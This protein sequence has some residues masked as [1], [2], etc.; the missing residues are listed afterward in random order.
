MERQSSGN[1][2][3]SF[4]AKLKEAL[5]MNVS[6]EREKYRLAEA[7]TRDKKLRTELTQQI[8]ILDAQVTDK[9]Q[10]LAS[11]SA[12]FIRMKDA[13]EKAPRQRLGAREA[14]LGTKRIILKELD[15]LNKEATSTEMKLNRAK[16]RNNILREHINAF[17]REQV[18]FRK[19][20]EKM[21]EELREAKTNITKAENEVEDAYEQRRKAHEEM[22]EL[23]KQFE[24]DKR[25]RQEEWQRLT[26]QIEKA[27]ESA[28]PRT[29]SARSGNS[30]LS[31]N[32]QEA[33]RKKIMRSQ[34][35]MQS[36][37]DALEFAQQKQAVFSA[38]LQH[39]KQ[40]T[41]YGKIADVIALFNR[42][43][44]EKFRKAQAAQRLVAEI[45][46]LE[47]DVTLLQGEVSSHETE[48]ARLKAERA[49][50]I[51]SL[52]HQ[53]AEA[54]AQVL[55]TQETGR[56]ALTEVRSLY[57]VIEFTFKALGIDAAVAGVEPTGA[58]FAGSG[59]S[60]P[61]RSPSIGRT[62]MSPARAAS[63]SS[64]GE[65]GAS[66]AKSRRQKSLS[67][68]TSSAAAQNTLRSGVS[69][70]S[71]GAYIGAIENRSADILQQF[72]VLV[73]RGDLATEADFDA[74]LG[75]E[76]A[77]G[78][79]EGMELPPM[80]EGEVPA[81]EGGTAGF[82]VML[83]PA[84]KA[85][86]RRRSAAFAHGS[87]EMAKRILSPGGLGPSNPPG[88]VKAAIATSA[89]IA[90]ITMDSTHVTPD[91]QLEM[92]GAGPGEDPK[93]MP[94]ETLKG[95]AIRKLTQDKSIRALKTAASAAA[96]VLVQ[97][98]S[99]MSATMSATQ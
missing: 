79:E 34:E 74:N 50:L 36:D 6:L 95:I 81:E 63:F 13:D 42:F 32:E 22:K 11:Y 96:S 62:P 25:E 87:G 61:A 91:E 53:A 82:R 72:A 14:V 55:E 45:E 77:E 86:L 70:S 97:P 69:A 35:K 41:G 52:D 33:L 3:P 23:A 76:S 85:A 83:S 12:L 44:E 29:P 54:E 19:L 21:Q 59:G 47:K 16:E 78:A 75:P 9:R 99:N 2:S 5:A 65:E 26:V 98:S 1:Q 8:M 51:G 17:R 38:A 66:P 67:I 43:E 24:L 60:S 88:R 31:P 71:L 94:T 10:K 46:R 57:K 90:S 27:T 64:F 4:D 92:T 28:S 80:E 48:N 84:Q 68:Y 30:L 40:S 56:A 89:L 73:T 20:F 15:K 39:I 58:P 37:S 18:T 7:I 49:A 93:P